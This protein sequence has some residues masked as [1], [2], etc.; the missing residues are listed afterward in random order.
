M[1]DLSIE[2]KNEVVTVLRAR[3]TDPN[4]ASRPASTQWIFTGRP[5]RNLGQSH[6]PR[7]RV[8]QVTETSRISDISRKSKYFTHIQI[9]V[10]VWQGVDGKDP[11]I[12]AISGT[13]YEGDKLLDYIARDV[14][15]ALDDN[16]SDFDD[17]TNALFNFK[18][19]AN[20]PSRDD[21]DQPQVRV[22]TVEVAFDYYR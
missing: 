16:K 19:L 10:Y 22:K 12:I 18:L 21:E 11:H 7:I 15:S 17:D 13:N 8:E 6:F 9:D 1:S 3:L 5:R 20:L 14:I 2:P 4:S